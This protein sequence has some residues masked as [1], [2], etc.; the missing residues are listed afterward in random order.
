M[1]AS[2]TIANAYASSLY[3]MS[4]GFVRGVVV[5]LEPPTLAQVSIV[6]CL[7]EHESSSLS[8]S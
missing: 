1:Y 8:S 7:L 3:T 6:H 2:E 5:D 4:H